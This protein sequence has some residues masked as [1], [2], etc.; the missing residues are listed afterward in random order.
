V[1]VS[2]F[3]HQGT[4]LSSLQ[5]LKNASS[6]KQLAAILNIQPSFLS[7]TLYI[8]QAPKY[9]TFTI[10]KKSGGERQIDAP[11]EKLKSIQRRVADLLYDCVEEIEKAKPRRHL[12]HGFRRGRSIVTNA[13]AHTN[14]RFVLNLDIQN[15]FPTINFGR[16][17]GFFIKNNVFQLHERVA[18][19]LA[20]I[21]CNDSLPQGSPCSP[22]ISDLVAHV[23][24]VRLVRLAK[25]HGCS[26]SRYADD[27]T[28]STNEREFPIQLAAFSQG[29]STW[30]IGTALAATIANADYNINPAKTR[31]QCRASRQTVTGLTVNRKVNIQATYYR[32]A[33]AMCYAAFQAGEYHRPGSD[34]PISTLIEIEGIMNHVDHVK[35]STDD[36]D[37][38]EKKKKLT[39]SRSLYRALLFFRYFVC[40]DRPLI[41]CEGKT[42]PVYLK[43]AIHKLAVNYPELIE[44]VEGKPKL[45]FGF[46]K[47]GDRS[48]EVMRLGGGTGD[49]KNLLI[50]YESM[51][52]RFKFAPLKFPVIVL[53]DNDSGATGAFSFLKD[54]YKLN[55]SVKSTGA[56]YFVCNNLYMIKTPENLPN[57]TS[58][59]E[60]LFD[61]ALLAGEFE[62]KTFNKSNGELGP[63]E[64]GKV[65]FSDYVRSN[66][67]KIVFSGFSPL[68][69]RIVAVLNHY[70]PP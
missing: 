40:L 33:R 60:D 27:L 18:T 7:F 14:R 61:P 10:P 68:L 66:A 32:N 57:G 13:R 58:T 45:K 12:S 67:E 49:L 17:R 8:S 2:Q 35:S 3:S 56:F 64:F 55:P 4:E 54:K 42:D 51:L 20:Q 1:P 5:K 36:R 29:T 37:E 43:A 38:D 48:T 53:L 63:H 39:G 24:D 44:V 31:M 50:H 69:D 25:A 30:N 52:A 11:N 21:A 22:I 23:L 70:T 59:I 16:V 28:F 9:S 26:Y 65:Q 15:F 34:K 6:L 19:V 41:L 47:Y 46:F 62:G